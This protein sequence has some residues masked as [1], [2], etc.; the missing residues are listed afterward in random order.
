MKNI[1]ILLILNILV[2]NIY[3]C[4]KSTSPVEDTVN[5]PGYYAPGEVVVGLV[6]T[7][8]YK[9]FTNFLDTLDLEI[10]NLWWGHKICAIADS[11]DMGYY[12]EIFSNDSSYELISELGYKSDTL[13]VAIIFN[14]MN[15]PEA[16][17]IKLESAGLIV[18]DIKIY[19]KIAYLRC[20]IGKESYWEKFLLTYDFIRYAHLDYYPVP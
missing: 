20:T 8:T 14:W 7:V 15:T 1:L 18:F 5:Q 3:S 11:N 17:S 13:Y 16:D 9:F 19:S 4:K 2:L 12:H 10:L 6:D